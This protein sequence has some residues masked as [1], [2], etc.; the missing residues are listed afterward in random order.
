MESLKNI[1]SANKIKLTKPRQEVFNVLNTSDKPLSIKEIIMLIKKAEKTS[2][3]R[4]LDIFTKLNIVEIKYIGWK[5]SYE[6]AEPFRQH[7]HHL[8]CVKC[9]SVVIID[10][11]KLEKVIKYIAND[12]GY[13]DVKHHVE[14]TGT[15]KN[16]S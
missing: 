4:T 11:P 1:L 12:Y 3:Y 10:Q 8:V 9:N 15:C 13:I 5:K 2:V 14:L 7:H 16:C 6:L